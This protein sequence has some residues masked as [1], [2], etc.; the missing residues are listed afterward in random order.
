MTE[1]KW[2]EQPAFETNEF[3]VDDRVRVYGDIVTERQVYSTSDAFVWMCPSLVTQVGS[4]EKAHFKQ[5][6]LLKKVEPP[7]AR[8]WDVK[9]I[10]ASNRNRRLDQ[11]IINEGPVSVSGEHIKLREVLDE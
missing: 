11:F 4:T 9:Y 1:T 10:S 3:Q 6:R 2:E 8:E 5:C 7:K